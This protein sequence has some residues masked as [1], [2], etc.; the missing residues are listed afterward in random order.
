MDPRN[1]SKDFDANTI[2][3]GHNRFNNGV[4]F[5]TLGNVLKRSWYSNPENLII[6]FNTLYGEY[7]WQ[8]FAIYPNPSNGDYLITSFDSDEEYASFLEMVKGRSIAKFDVELTP[9]DKI[10][11]LST[12]LDNSRRLVVHA[13]LLDN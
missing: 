11:T 12:C 10:L 5:G 13:V 7:K 2:I 3:Y 6:T 1:D 4:M 9:Q 8:I